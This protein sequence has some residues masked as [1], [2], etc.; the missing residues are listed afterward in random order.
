MKPFKREYEYFLLLCRSLNISGAAEEAGIQ[1]AGLSKSLRSLEDELKQPLFYRT[2][3]GLRLTPYGEIF[4]NLLT[5]TATNWE[6]S[7]EKELTKFNEVAG[8]FKIG[9]H[10]AVANGLMGKFYPRLVEENEGLRLKLE[11]KRS[12]EV[13]R[14]VVEYN[15]DFGVVVNPTRHEDLVITELQRDFSALWASTKEPQKRV[16]YY[17]PEMLEI[18]QTLKKYSRYKLVEVGD[19]EVIASLGRRSQGVC[20]LP[21]AVA[22]R[23][24]GLHQI[25]RPVME[26]KICLIYRHDILKSRAFQEIVRSI[27]QSFRL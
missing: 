25:G 7:L 1:Q 16:L 22:G 10:A 12:A 26:A 17:N 19:Y 24:P 4:K 9:S 27:R 15:L 13:T 23:S 2:N 3:R 5:S 20:L 11:L 6:L 18:V 14:D 8:S 21:S